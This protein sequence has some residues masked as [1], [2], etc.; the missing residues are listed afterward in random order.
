MEVIIDAKEAS[1]AIDLRGSCDVV[2]VKFGV[3][4]ITY[5]IEL[6]IANKSAG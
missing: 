1:E 5:T 4:I 3:T 2:V 6:T